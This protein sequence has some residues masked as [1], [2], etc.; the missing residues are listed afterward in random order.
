MDIIS[1]PAFTE[2]T[3]T[4][5]EFNFVGGEPLNITLRTGDSFDRADTA[6]GVLVLHLVEPRKGD[7]QVHYRNVTWISTH[8]RVIRTPIAGP[9]TSATLPPHP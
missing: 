9:P 5:W 7:I 2:E 4:D 6:T 8:T 1:E 3:V